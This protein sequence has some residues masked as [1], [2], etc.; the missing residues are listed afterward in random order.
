MQ[1][2]Q[3]L[4]AAAKAGFRADA[5]DSSPHLESSPMDMAWR[6]GRFLA[7]TGRGCIEGAK[8]GRGFSVHVWGSMNYGQRFKTRLAFAYRP[9]WRIVCEG[10]DPRDFL[11]DCRQASLV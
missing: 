7:S 1:R 11:D 2:D 6:A 10:P 9:N 8:M 5:G 4:T 3:Q